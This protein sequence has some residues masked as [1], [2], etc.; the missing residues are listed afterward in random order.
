MERAGDVRFSGG[1]EHP[2]GGRGA[3]TL[4]ALTREQ[5]GE[6]GWV[7]RGLASVPEAIRARAFRALTEAKG[8]VHGTILGPVRMQ[9]ACLLLCLGERRPAPSWETMSRNVHGELRRRFLDGVV[10]KSSVATWSDVQR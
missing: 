2:G 8:P 9:G 6:M 10:P 4:D 5:G 1:R 3:Q 7:T